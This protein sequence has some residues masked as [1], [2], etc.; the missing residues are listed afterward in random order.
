M[1]D[2]YFSDKNKNGKKGN[3]QQRERISADKT[4]SKKEDIVSGN[5]SKGSSKKEEM[6]KGFADT[7]Y[8][9]E[10]FSLDFKKKAKEIARKNAAEVPD[11][12]PYEVKKPEMISSGREPLGKKIISQNRTPQGQRVAKARAPVSR[13]PKGKKKKGSAKAKV[14]LAL[15]SLLMVLVLCVGAY[16]LVVLSGIDYEEIGTNKYV[17]ESELATSPY[18]K[19]V[20]FIGCDARGDVE[21]NRSDTMILLSIDTKNRKLKLTSFLRDSYVYIPEKGFSNKLNSSFSYGGQKCLMDTLEYNFGVNIDNYVMVNF[22]AFRQLVNLLGGITVDG[23]TEREAKYMREEV[24]IPSVKAGKNKMNGKTAL[25]Y[26]RIRYI[27]NDFRRTERQRKVISAIIDKV[28]KTDIFTLMN[29]CKEVLPNVSTDIKT[30]ELLGLGVNAVLRYLRYDIVQQQIPA[31]DEW[32]D[33]WVG[34]Q[35]VVALDFEANKRILKEFIYE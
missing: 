2:I 4:S 14:F 6:K 26:C 32:A 16:G 34:S 28:I 10:S 3:K 12:K 30:T 20:L 25:W 33:R 17:T 15:A 29:I 24:K 8:S 23:V 19:N 11:Y 9:D 5:Q 7:D 31:D 27:D 18:V 1:D 21:G 22:N 13:A 35:Q